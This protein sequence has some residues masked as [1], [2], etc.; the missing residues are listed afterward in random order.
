[1]NEE[2]LIEHVRPVTFKDRK[3]L[4]TFSYSKIDTF[5]NCPYQYNEKYNN[6]L[7]ASDTSLALELGTLCHYVLE[8]KGKGIRNKKNM[9][10]ESLCEILNNGT[11]QTDAKTRESILGVTA[12]KKKYFDSWYERDN[13][14]GM[15]YEEKMEVFHEVLKTEMSEADM[16][17]WTPQYFELPF[18]FVWDDKVIIHGFIDRVDVKDGEYRTIDYKTSKKIYDAS[19]VSTSLQFGIYALAILT[20]FDKLPVENIY[21]F[22]LID[23]KQY[24]LTKG[25]EKR[26]VKALDKVF[27]QIEK[28]EKEGEWV[29]KP[30]PLCYWCSYCSNNPNAHAFKNICNYYILWTPTNKTF[31]KKSEWRKVNTSNT[32]KPRRKIIF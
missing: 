9:G 6:K 11:T 14:S 29:P 7:Y 10:Y 5:K 15:N 13:A 23:E 2:I 24:A 8:Q 28:C 21:R 22:I 32:E 12:L 3:T 30:T 26:L 20:M 19:K 16:E 31:E 18:E 27:E 25:W 4:P 1:M 17:G